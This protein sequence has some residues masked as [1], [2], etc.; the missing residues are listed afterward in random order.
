MATQAKLTFEKHHLID[1]T[2]TAEESSEG[3]KN[4]QTQEQRQEATDMPEIAK[5]CGKAAGEDNRSWSALC[6][7]RCQEAAGEAGTKVFSDMGN[8]LFSC[9][10]AKLQLQRAPAYAQNL[11]MF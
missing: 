4:L 3:P 10:G 5:G 7:G 9:P 2:Q 8:I 6:P 1:S 11:S